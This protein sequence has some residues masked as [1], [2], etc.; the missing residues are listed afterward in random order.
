LANLKYP[1]SVLEEIMHTSKSLNFIIICLFLVLVSLSTKMEIFEGKC[2]SCFL[3]VTT[4]DTGSY[5]V[6]NALQTFLGQH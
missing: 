6:Y 4:Y 1:Q 3:S 5:F 2:S